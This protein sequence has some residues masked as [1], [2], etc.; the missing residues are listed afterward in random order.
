MKKY[1]LFFFILFNLSVY[2]QTAKVFEKKLSA[3]IE[4]RN[5]IIERDDEKAY[6]ALTQCNDELEKLVLQFT[7]SNP[8]TLAYSFKEMPNGLTVVTSADGQFRIYSWNTLEGGTMQYYKNVFQYKV[9]GKVYSKLSKTETESNDGSVNFY[10]LNEVKS[11]SKNYY[12]ASSISVGSSAAYYYEAKVFSI[13][14]GK[15][16]ENAKLIK[17]RSGLKNTLGYDVDLS[18]SSNSDRTDGVEGRDYMGMVYDKKTKTI[19]IPL[20]NEDGKITKKKIRYQFTG[21]YFE[22][23]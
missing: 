19:S 14:D 22:K 20:I 21:T 12:V 13:E 4:K 15:L 8:E 1:T 2:S 7:S 3:L 9:N 11:N 5:A 18:S 23:I 16:N 10:D 17:T 6:E